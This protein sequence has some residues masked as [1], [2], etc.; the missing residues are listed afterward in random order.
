MAA[1]PVERDEDIANHPYGRNPPRGGEMSLIPEFK[2]D[3]SADPEIWIRRV[4]NTA[5]TYKWFE[6]AWQSAATL[7]LTGEALKW[8]EAITRSMDYP[9]THYNGCPAGA[10]D[11]EP[12]LPRDPSWPKFKAA[13]FERFRP[14]DDTIMATNAIMNLRQGS[15]EGVHAFYDRC[16]V[17]VDKKNFQYTAVQKADPA[18]RATRDIDLFSFM[19]AG[20]RAD[21][22]RMALGG[23]RPAR[24]IA[25]LLQ[26]CMNAEVIL[27]TNH[28]VHEIE[29]TP[30]PEKEK[31]PTS[32]QGDAS[33]DTL[34]VNEL[35]KEI[36][37]LR[38]TMKCFK[39]GQIGHLRRDCKSQ[40]PGGNTGNR[41][42]RNQTGRGQPRGRGRGQGRGNRQ[43][44]NRGGGNWRNQRGQ[45]S[46]QMQ[47]AW[48]PQ[49]NFGQPG[50][51]HPGSYYQN[52]MIQGPPMGPQGYFHPY[53]TQGNHSH[54]GGPNMS[55]IVDE[56]WAVKAPGNW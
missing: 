9:Y 43:G 14:Q 46:N 8:L 36:D 5:K 21:I 19:A 55:S 52:N 47:R 7:K 34:T 15:Q 44:G 11:T 56:P 49:A 4:E 37:A 27:T 3:G 51:S 18:Y 24:N 22:R 40:T 48:V 30:A 31:A 32:G 16:V 6:S 35:R 25:E 26:Y 20:L 53:T 13:F 41:P 12:E 42:P 1:Y 17:A 2:G 50:S 54:S 45:G 38:A 23:Q 39:C 28:S 29:I 33:D 10:D